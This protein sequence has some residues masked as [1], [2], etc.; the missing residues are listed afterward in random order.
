MSLFDWVSLLSLIEGR[1]TARLQSLHRTQFRYGV[2][3]VCA[4]LEGQRTVKRETSKST[5]PG[6]TLPTV[7][8]RAA[9]ARII[10]G[11]APDLARNYD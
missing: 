2:H 11:H 4:R 3:D 6:C 5:G 7:A 10:F 1:G 8:A 9:L